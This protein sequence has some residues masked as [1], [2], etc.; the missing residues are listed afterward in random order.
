MNKTRRSHATPLLILM[1]LLAMSGCGESKAPSKPK[2]SGFT[3]VTFPNG[4]VQF[5]MPDTY[6][7]RSE[8]DDAIAVTPGDETGVTLRFNLHNLPDGVVEEFLESQA[9]PRGLQIVRVGDKTTFSETE[10]RSEAGHDYL[11]TFWQIGFGDCLVVMSSEVDKMHK[12]DQ[13]V[14]AVLKSGCQRSPSP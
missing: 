4:P 1:V 5:S 11:M 2:A 7:Q 13:A 8:P 10:T 3:T 9:E 14:K 6:S 12:G